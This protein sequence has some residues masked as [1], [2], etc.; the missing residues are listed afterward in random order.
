MGLNLFGGGDS[1][2]TNTST[3]TTAQDQRVQIG[4]SAELVVSPGAAYATPGGGAVQ[5]SPYS[6]VVQTI[7]NSGLGSDDLKT[8]LDDV[9]GQ[10]TAQMASVQSSTKALTD[11][12]AATK[13]PAQTTLSALLPLLLILG[14][15][16]FLG[17]H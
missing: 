17:G 9:L 14:I 2:T 4:G 3:T 5:A 7:T 1:K 12:V 6:S 13:A 15:L 10:Q 8:L 16:F 11:I